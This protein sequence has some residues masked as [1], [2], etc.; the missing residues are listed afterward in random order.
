MNRFSTTYRLLLLMVMALFATM[1]QA[2]PAG[3]Q[4]Y[5]QVSIQASQVQGSHSN[6]PVLISITDTD[7]RDNVQSSNGYDIL[8]AADVNGNTILSHEI[9]SYN[10][11]TGELIAWVQI[12]SLSGNTDTDIYMFYGNGAV[13]TNPSTNAIWNS[14]YFGIYH[15]ENNVSDASGSNNNLTNRSTSNLGN[16]KIGSARNLNNSS[17]VASNSNSGQHLEVPNRIFSGVGDFTFSGWVQLDRANTNWERVF[18]FGRNTN[19]NFFFTPSVGTNSPSETR[20]RITGNGNSGEQGAIISNSTL[21]IGQW[22]HWAI[23]LDDGANTLIVYRNG[24]LYGTANNVTLTPNSIENS[25]SN[26][27][28]RSNYG[29]DD[30]IDAKFDEFRLA[31]STFSSGWI[32]TEFN[33]QNNPSSFY[34]VSNQQPVDGNP[35]PAPQNVSAEA[36]AGG[37]IRLSFD[38]VDE[39]GS[40]VSLYSIRRGTSQGG[41]Y[42][43][44]ATITD[45]ESSS[46][47][48]PDNGV[49]DGLTYYYVVVA[50]DGSGNTSVPS[51]EVSA[52]ADQS[53]PT[54]EAVTVNRSNLQLDYNESLDGGSVPSASSFTVNVNSSEV[55]I[56]NVSISGDKVN[57][58]IN[59][60]AEVGDDV[61]VSY[62]AGGNPIQDVAGNN[63]GNLTNQ[64]V[65]NNTS[66]IP[67]APVN[68][69]ATALA[70]GDIEINF[71]DVDSEGGVTTY[72][73][74]RASNAGGPYTQVATVGDDESARYSYTNTG[75]TDGGTYYYVVTAIDGS[76]NESPESAEAS[77]TA[78]ASGPVLNVASINGSTLQLD[79]NENLSP[80]SI[81]ASGDFTIRVNGN[82]RTVTNV[83]IIGARINLSLS[84][85]VVS[86]DIVEVDYSTGTN[87]VQDEIGN[88]ASGFSNQPVTNNTFNNSAFGPDPCP[89]TNGQDVAWACF[90]GVFGGTSMSAFVGGL[91]IATVDAAAGSNTTFAP[92]ALQSWASGAYAGDEFNGPQLN[93]S[94]ATGNTT[95]IDI[96]IPSG[97]PSD[98][99]LLSLNRLAPN[100]GNT[101]YTLEAFDNSGSKVSLNGWQ[102]GQGTDGGLCTNNVNLVYTNGNTTL[103]FQ[104]T[105][106]GNA[107]CSISSTPLWIKIGNPDMD[108]IELR[109][110]HTANDNIYV[111]L[112]VRA[113]FGDAPSTYTTQYSSRTQ[114]PAFHLLNNDGNDQVF[115][116]GNV[117]PDGNGRPNGTSSGDDTESSGLGAGDDEDAISSM[118]ELHT[119]QPSYDVTLVCSGGG[120][121][122]GWVDFNQSGSFDAGEYDSG[123]CSAGSV[124]L[125]W[126]GLSGLVTG[127]T[128]A[129]F[130]IATNAAEV[131]NPTGSA[132]DGEVE[133]YMVT[134]TPPP[135]PDL[136]M[137]KSVN[138]T[139]PIEGETITFTLQVG[140]SSDEFSATGVQV[141]DQLPSGITFTSANAEQGSYNSGTGIWNV[142]TLAPE[143]TVS[144]ELMA[145]VNSG[146]VGSTIENEA[147]ISS[148]DQSDPD[149][150]NN[151][152]TT[153]ITVI[154]ETADINVQKVVDN[155]VPL[156][157]EYITYTIYVTNNGPKDATNLSLIDQLPSGLTFQS[158]TATLGSYNQSTGIWTIGA[159]A[160]GASASLAINVTVDDETQ[161]NSISNTASINTLDQND[162]NADNN[163]STAVVD[164]LIPG[165]P[166]S[167]NDRPL[168]TFENGNLISGSNNQIGAVYRFNNVMNGVYA[169]V[170]VITINNA[171]LLNVDDANLSQLPEEFSP[172]IENIGGDDGYVDFKI[173]FFDNS[174]NLPRYM[175][176]A[177]T[178]SDID[179]TGSL[180]DLIGFQNLS[181]FTVEEATNLINDYANAFVTFESNNFQDT[182]PTYSNYTDYMVYATYTNEAVFNLRAGIKSDGTTDDRVIS[183]SFDPCKINDFDDPN[184]ES[185]VDVGVTKE[186]DDVTPDV[187]QDITYTI[188]LANTKTTPATGIVI[189]DVLS[190][191]LTFKSATPS[192]GSYNSSNGEWTVGSLQGL[193]SATLEIVAE[194]ETGTEGETISNTATVAEVDGVDLVPNNNTT[195]ID[196]VV[197]DPNS[198]LSCTAPP[199][200]SFDTYS[201]EQ[202]V[203]EQVNAVYRFTNV[204]S[205]LDALVTIKAINNAILNELD[206]NSAG[207]Q[208][209]NF[210]PLFVT[211]NGTSNGY[212]DWEIRIVQSG[213]DIPVKRSFSMTG[214]DIDGYQTGGESIRDY[215]GFSQNQ[216]STIES[217]TNLA[218]SN[219]GPFAIFASSTTT[220][221]QGSFD[222][223]HMAYITFNYTSRLELRTGSIP[224]GGY[225]SERLVDIDFRGCL[226]QE[227]DNPI[228]NTRNADIQVTKTV[229]EENP[230]ENEVINF[231][232]NVTNNGP[233][234]ATE[235]DISE[236]LPAG[237]SL[238]QATPT[239]GTFNQLT[240][241]WA[242]GT[243]NSGN[244]ATLSL[245]TSVDSGVEADSLVNMAYVKGLNQF[246]PNIA[247]DTS[248]TVVRISIE[249]EGTVFR[250]KTGNGVADGDLSFNDAS[251]DQTGLQ[252]VKVHLF[253]DGGDGLPDGADDEYEQTVVTGNKG[254][255]TFQ[256]GQG[257]DYWVAVDS[258]SG[259]LTNGSTWA[260]Q[261][262]AP[263]GAYCADG[264]NGTVVS[265]T[266]GNCFG[267]RRGNVSDNIPASP[268]GADIAQAEHVAKLTVTDQGIEDIDFGFSFNV[269]TNTRDGDDDGSAGRSIQG[270]LRQ[271]IQNANAISGANTMRFVPA[272]PVNNAN[273]WSITLNSALP[274]VTDPLT[275]ISGIAYSKDSPLVIRNENGGT[276]GAGGAVGTAQSA[277]G[278]F[279]RKELEI[280]L[281]D[282]GDYA[283]TIN[284]SGAVVVKELALFNNSNG[285][286]VQNSS[287]GTIEN[288]L[289]GLRADGTNPGGNSR[290]GQGIDF[291][292]SA[293]LS[294]LVQKNFIAYTTG[295]GVRSENANASVTFFGNEVF[296]TAQ[297]NTEA[298][299]LSV[300]GTWTIEQNLIHE[301][302]N[303][304]SDPVTGGSGIELG[305]T[306]SA[307]QNSIIRDN[308][309]RHNTVA[310]ISVLHSVSNSLIEANVI[311]N[312]GTNYSSGGQNLGAGIKLSFPDGG[313][314]QGIRIT[315]NSFLNNFGLSVDVVSN[316]SGSGQADGVNSNDGNIQSTSV[317]PNAGLDYP[318]FTLATVEGSDLRVEGF[319]GTNA[320]K[321]NGTY[322]IEIYKADNDGN[323]EGL[324]EENG[325]LVR[326]HGEG[327]QFIG[328]VTTNSDGTFNEAVTIPNSV[329]LAT[330]DRITAITIDGSN[331]TSEFSANQRIVPTGVTITGYVY[332]DENHNSVRENGENGIQ[333]VTVV[334]YNVA[335]NNCKSV[336]T[337]SDGLYQFTNVLNGE[338][339]V[340]EAY[341]QSV[342]TPD[343]CTPTP[344]DPEEHVST[345][346]NKR[347][348][349]VNNQPYTMNFGDFRGAKVEG[350]VYNDNGISGG[351]ANNAQ[352]DGGEAGLSGVTVKAATTGGSTLHEVQSKGSGAFELYISASEISDGS[353]VEILEQGGTEYTTT[354]GEVGNTQGTYTL[355]EDKVSFTYA[356]GEVYTGVKFANVRLSRL[357]TNGEKN[358]Q[359]GTSGFFQ[360]TFE[361]RTAGKVTFSIENTSNPD[362]A[363]WPVV[364]YRDLNCNNSVES[365][366][367]ILDENTE[368]A[369][370]ANQT[371]CLLLKVTVPQGVSTG[372]SNSS[373][374]TANFVLD[375]TSP[376][377]EQE[378][379]RTDLVRVSITEGGLVIVKEVNKGQALPG[380]SLTY[381]IDYTNNGSEPISSMEIVDNTPSYTSFTSATCNTLPNSLT[382]CT[383]EDP[384]S[385]QEGV[386]K[387]IFQG[388]LAPGA[389]GSVTYVVKIHE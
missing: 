343:V 18:D 323:N 310:G 161:G 342:P 176:F 38:D 41:P 108:R 384:G 96:D 369:V 230:L 302:G 273:W 360:H 21:D 291:S 305:Q 5:K 304:S 238:I 383:I 23:V 357:L 113:D 243:L 175:S 260:E 72:S 239:Q 347:P 78:D 76:G 14:N 58:T 142:G 115:F 148:V 54:L 214:L 381:T 256:I 296:Q 282:M 349:T 9:E 287:S 28:G 136:V 255:Y 377:I 163:T 329:T 372:A 299:G 279:S 286:N 366:E 210:S 272:A 85:P 201:L 371:M 246:D 170:E 119:A 73:I 200:F 111:G 173:S 332:Q 52:T 242:I 150:T 386:I 132:S 311:N 187:G 57:L 222:T 211:Q 192:Q 297:E 345:T 70:G 315:E 259:A 389:S 385:G 228:V 172:S 237:L 316:Y 183:V 276:V 219:E 293:S 134:I 114:P 199:T 207:D 289:V 61:E 179:G 46:Y 290:A 203:P 337:N 93:P 180:K 31:S 118:P 314:I 88:N 53:P 382:G 294:I 267:G 367:P 327:R 124:T 236:Q 212:I 90:N 139:Q 298:D 325:T 43:E 320:N 167:C 301:N 226:N 19:I 353:V 189:E 358:L 232:V 157:G 29:A 333:D 149:L 229:D 64:T 16:G 191:D 198:N 117:D 376:D 338:Y 265:S 11:S 193:Q 110:V 364:L 10:S 354:G 44:V 51:A 252:N 140:N 344:V 307:S 336:I 129:R 26:Y 182:Q 334:L 133:D 143:D 328:S 340:I 63:A 37:D 105:V 285:I 153:G 196:I 281:N 352:Q 374:I 363:I 205:G 137:L 126:T 42:S 65:T 263:A 174:T 95:S 350:T 326:P 106:S 306:G 365:G 370:T 121:V 123:T 321:L 309:I 39:T 17:N 164:V 235:L 216:S 135:T 278:S 152:A 266:A 274:P 112:G 24:S 223:D 368:V 284:T 80:A 86:G 356:L 248:K 8:F 55:T 378:L 341:G 101:S 77:A 375:N 69:T 270:G 36:V 159:L 25:N 84:Q 144:L 98:A 208:A 168:L 195:T 92:N 331:N 3:Y 348:V 120:A 213:T 94:G 104:P 231:T 62:T 116:G 68:V 312:N 362:N 27:F 359:P 300:I 355:S 125:N 82:T 102:T 166:N 59:P 75:L 197:N 107:S 67:G 91:E 234:N 48:F 271:F 186:V 79:Y 220:D 32:A 319:V 308:T 155:A 264:N 379:Q 295:N 131:A 277:I 45:D 47:L 109:K 71:D 283:F 40:G 6:F 156:E 100:G 20:V 240:K 15:F 251:G 303:S 56:T 194:V 292:G 190:S 162:N 206:D 335:L 330:N 178:G 215:M 258:R 204:A 233:Q 388:S 380:A 324:I 185:V 318:Q 158:A 7:L 202:G 317:E 250:D 128:H 241:T 74:Q 171:Q 4:Y 127:T 269:V 224:T 49:T 151:T 244:S 87:P 181:S 34:T 145:T 217:G 225:D 188:N 160:N 169:K 99:I 184:T 227:F 103:E 97:V 218:L 60:E 165:A 138:N 1:A 253:K 66:T 313:S 141:T 261:T 2:Q 373:V 122:G 30:Y 346:P 322:T 268:T 351:T 221:G 35:P 387:W 33:N 13:T 130:R 146:T 262:Y 247:N 275:T 245:R 249:A 209:A 154:P 22:V 50:V 147:S 280:N 83:A 12:P 288:N 339:E 89:I 257:G 361:S 177:A 81:P 254:E